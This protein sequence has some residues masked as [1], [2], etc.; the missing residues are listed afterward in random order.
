MITTKTCEICDC[1]DGVKGRKSKLVASITHEHGV[2]YRC[3]KHYNIDFDPE[4]T[5]IEPIPQIS[6]EQYIDSQAIENTQG[7]ID[8]ELLLD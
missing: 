7:L 6:R 2:F 1:E 5:Q 8:K 4:F 3:N